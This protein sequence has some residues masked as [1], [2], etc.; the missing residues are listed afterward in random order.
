MAVLALSVGD[1]QGEEKKKRC[2]A[3][4]RITAVKMM[5]R[6]PRPGQRAEKYILVG[7]VRGIRGF[8]TGSFHRELPKSKYSLMG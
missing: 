7:G 8:L 2:P 6:T 1:A 5:T 4:A 3:D